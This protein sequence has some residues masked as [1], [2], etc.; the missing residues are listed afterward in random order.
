MKALGTYQGSVLSGTLVRISRP[1]SPISD[2]S[3]A[4]TSVDCGSGMICHASPVFGAVS[5]ARAGKASAVATN[6]NVRVRTR[7]AAVGVE[8]V[9][10]M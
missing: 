4:Y 1:I 3:R 9:N 7:D 8:R 5:C 2:E 6:A 10:V